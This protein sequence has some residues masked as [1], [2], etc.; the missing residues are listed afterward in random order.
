M[1]TR[2]TCPQ[3]PDAISW[4]AAKFGRRVWCCIRCGKVLGEAPLSSAYGWDELVAAFGEPAA[5]AKVLGRRQEFLVLTGQ[6]AAEPSGDIDEAE[7]EP[8]PPPPP[9]PPLPAPPPPI[10]HRQP[11]SAQPRAAA[12][13]PAVTAPA[14]PAEQP[15]ITVTHQSTCRVDPCTCAARLRA[16]NKEAHQ[17]AAEHLRA[18]TDLSRYHPED[19]EAIRGHLMRIILRIAE[20]P[21]C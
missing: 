3:H 2:P 16:L 6:R 11:P 13:A 18:L 9:S 8:A 4:S 14:L 10:S 15:R 1:T 21:V 12:A 19:R 20:R 7:A 5:R 17:L